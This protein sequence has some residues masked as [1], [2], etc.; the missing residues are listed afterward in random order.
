MKVTAYEATI[1]NGQVKILGTASLPEHA[2][3]YIIAP[4]AD[5][6]PTRLHVR[7][8]RLVRPEDARDFIKEVI[9]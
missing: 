6:G 4:D 7:S 1:E 8:P 3:V 9:A 5:P 2:R